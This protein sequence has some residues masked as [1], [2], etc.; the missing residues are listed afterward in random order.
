MNVARHR[1]HHRIRATG[2]GDEFDVW[3]YGPDGAEIAEGAAAGDDTVTFPVPRSGV[4]T[5]GVRAV[6]PPAGPYE[7]T[8]SI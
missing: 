2:A 6:L 7:G 8:A 1:R 5:I 3:V 4:Y